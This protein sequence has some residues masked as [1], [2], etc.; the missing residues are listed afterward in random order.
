MEEVAARNRT[1]F[2]AAARFFG[3]LCDI[4]LDDTPCRLFKPVTYM[5]ESG[6]AVGALQRYYRYEPEEMLIVHDEI[7]LPPGTVRLKRGG[8]HGGHNGLR[9]VITQLGFSD[10]H[11]VRIGVG[12]PGRAD[13]V[14]D[15]VLRRASADEQ[16]LINE[17]V[18]RALQV[19]PTIIAGNM[20]RAMNALHAKPPKTAE[21]NPSD[22]DHTHRPPQ[23]DG[24]EH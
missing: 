17:A 13:E 9:D 5:N 14:V 1:A 22:A 6:R 16:S 11:R 24:V 7:D 23:H 3:E 20:A 8:G 10:F 18:E 12:H 2:R 19:L 15:Y 21:D 4:E